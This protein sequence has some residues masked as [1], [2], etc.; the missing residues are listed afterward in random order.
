MF[1]D[2]GEDWEKAYLARA[3]G[4]VDGCGLH[5]AA[6]T[7]AKFA[8]QTVEHLQG[9]LQARKA[10]REQSIKNAWVFVLRQGQYIA[11]DESDAFWAGTVL[12][13]DA[14]QAQSDRVVLL[15]PPGT[16]PGRISVDLFDLAAN[17][18]RGVIPAPK[19]VPT[20]LLPRTPAHVKVALDVARYRVGQGDSDDSLTDAID[21][22]ELACRTALHEAQPSGFSAEERL[23]LR[24][25]LAH[26]QHPD[27]KDL[28]TT[29]DVAGNRLT[30]E[31]VLRMRDAVAKIGS[32][33]T[34]MAG[35][36][37]E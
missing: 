1:S 16:N 14:T 11:T 17:K 37:Q 22:V 18:G 29:R 4:G 25:L 20:H 19:A 3:A 35:L 26:L 12:T 24:C 2:E 27:V 31:A 8:D 36:P 32:L 6:P 10:E 5:G 13:V 23:V 33:I 9:R 21:G 7:C 34:T 15:A 28:L 30:P